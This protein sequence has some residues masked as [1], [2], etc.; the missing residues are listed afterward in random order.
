MEGMNNHILSINERVIR[1]GLVHVNKV[2]RSKTVL[3]IMLTSIIIK[4]LGGYYAL[5]KTVPAF[6]TLVWHNKTSIFFASL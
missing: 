5:K 1:K 3:E 4:L 6:C 2:T